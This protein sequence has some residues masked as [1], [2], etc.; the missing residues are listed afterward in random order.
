MSAQRRTATKREQPPTAASAR[1]VVD[2]ARPADAGAQRVAG[3]PPTGRPPKPAPGQGRPAK[4]AAPTSR[5]PKPEV[6]PARPPKPVEKA[7]V[8]PETGAR[9]AFANRTQGVRRLYADTLSEMRKV[10]WPDRETTKNLTLVVIAVS[11]VLGIL[12]GGVDFMLQALFE[13]L[14]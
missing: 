5:P 1:R 7:R 13:A 10:N 12:L 11:I 14:P 4:P 6:A 9:G 2:A 3:A 8:A